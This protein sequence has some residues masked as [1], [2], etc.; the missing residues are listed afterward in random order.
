MASARSFYSFRKEQAVNQE[1]LWSPLLR[2]IK[3]FREITIKNLGN[4]K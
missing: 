2:N 4:K 1:S 3:V